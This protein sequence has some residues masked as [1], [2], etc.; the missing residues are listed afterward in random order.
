V[1]VIPRGL[2]PAAQYF[3]NFVITNGSV[4]SPTGKFKLPPTAGSPLSTLKFFFFSCSNWPTGYFNAYDYASKYDSLDFWLHLGD[5]YYEYGVS[6]GTADIRW[7]PPPQGLQP[8][9][10]I[11]VLDDY[12]KRHALYRT[13]PGLQA[14]SASAALIAIWDDHEFTNNVWTNGAQNQYPG[15][16]EFYQRKHNAVRAYTEWM[17]IRWN[18]TTTPDFNLPQ[19][20]AI[21][22]TFQFGDLATVFMLEDR[23]TSRTNAGGDSNEFDPATA[24]SSSAYAAQLVGNLTVDSWAS[25]NNATVEKGMLDLQNAVNTRRINES[26]LMLGQSQ[27]DWVAAKTRESAAAGTVWQLYNTGVIMQDWFS[28]DPLGALAQR[29]APNDAIQ[30]YWQQAFNNATTTGSQYTYLSTSAG[31]KDNYGK[32][33]TVSAS[34]ASAARASAALGKYKI[35]SNNDAWQGYL[36]ARYKFGQAI[37]TSINPTIYAGDSHNFW[38]GYVVQQKPSDYLTNGNTVPTGPIIATEFDGGAVSSNG[39]DSNGRLPLDF[40]NAAW[41]AANPN[42]FHVEVRYRGGVFVTLTKENQHVEFTYVSTVASQNYKGFC[43][44]AFD[45]PA[46]TNTS[47]PIVARPGN[48]TAGPTSGPYSSSGGSPLLRSPYQISKQ[49]TMLAGTMMPTDSFLTASA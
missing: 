31:N 18:Y 11:Q 38:A 10:D 13:D 8:Q 33:M 5:Y 47:Q 36:Q 39:Q 22:R 27:L 7:Q 14:L 49:T 23:V 4:V 21:N 24:P 45:V 34:D 9:G 25:G 26:D 46:R 12:R 28:P 1:K 44:V 3:Y 20:Y 41:R 37:N 32:T 16:V 19:D 15:E 17:P 48:C 30:G 43:G 6:Q 40:V 2:A 29:I 42:M 35:N